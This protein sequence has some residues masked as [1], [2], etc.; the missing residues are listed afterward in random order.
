MKISDVRT[1]LVDAGLRTWIFVKIETDV[2]GLYGW[3][4]A[5]TELHTE[6]VAAA[7]RDLTP[8]LI[9][10]DPRRT[11]Y[12][13]QR[14]YRHPY[15]KGGIV[16]LSAIS[17]I[18]QALHDI[19]AKDLGVPLY[20]IL[21]G[22]VR[23][24]IRMYDHLGGGDPNAVYYDANVEAFAAHARQSVQDGYTALKILPVPRTG[25]LDG[26]CGLDQAERLMAAVRG[27]VGDPI[28]IMVDFH[29]RTTAAMAIQYGK[30]LEP[31]RP[32]F[33]EEPCQP[34]DIDGLVAVARA[35]STPI[36]TGERLGTRYDFKAL[37]ERRACAVAQPDVCHSGGITELRKISS[38]ADA[39]HV[40]MAPHNPLGPVAVMVNVHLAAA[41]P[42][43]LI[44]EYM[45][46]DVPW[47]N[48]VVD[49]DFVICDGVA[50]LPNRPGI[51]VE[52][53]ELAAARHPYIPSGDYGTFHADGSVADW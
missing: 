26:W 38:L 30:V 27:A 20:Q 6:G 42:N 32:W 46:S 48:E 2:P 34:E 35:L 33:I 15:F 43:F 29:G 9:G 18:D 50:Q 13:W 51:G 3:G 28:D 36:A 52:I 40:S 17:G 25:P 4:E 44:Q 11:E 49:A 37:F 24:H 31:F 16:E 53:D 45:R 22:A 21:G 41:T 39:Y 14:M 1:L 12:L 19:A 10:Q 8:L 47:R 5:T 23:S 7:V